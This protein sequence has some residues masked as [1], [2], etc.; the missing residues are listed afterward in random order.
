MTIFG[1]RD[2]GVISV[3]HADEGQY[4][5]YS[6]GY[7]LKYRF[8]YQYQYWKHVYLYLHG[9]RSARSIRCNC[10]WIGFLVLLKYY[11]H[12][13]QGTGACQA[14]QWHVRLHSALRDS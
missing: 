14:A 7:L 12:G 3:T 8:G 1:I 5:R 2:V 11:M 13:R 6:S 9:R 4:I 10:E